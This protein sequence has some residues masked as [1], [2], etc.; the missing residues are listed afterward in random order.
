MS[1]VDGIEY[2]KDQHFEIDQL[3]KLV[4]LDVYCYL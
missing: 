3:Q 2:D 1:L 4:P